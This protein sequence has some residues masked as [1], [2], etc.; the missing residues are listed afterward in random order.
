VKINEN[1]SQKKAQSSASAF[2]W[3]ASRLLI[4]ELM[5]A[6]VMEAEK[7]ESGGAD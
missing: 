5:M 1:L 2:K 4:V 3:C 7:C 6:V